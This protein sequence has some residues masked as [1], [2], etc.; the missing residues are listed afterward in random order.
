MLMVDA[1]KAILDYGVAKGTRWD[2]DR[3]ARTALA[4]QKMGVGCWKNP[5]CAATSII[6]S[7]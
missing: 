6:L 5:S 1:N 2:F 7:N 3:A 4:Y